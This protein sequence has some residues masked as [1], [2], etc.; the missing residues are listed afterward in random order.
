LQQ[1]GS[2]LGVPYSAAALSEVSKGAVKTPNLAGI[3]NRKP[4]GKF[5]SNFSI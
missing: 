5:S 3:G 4:A 1:N 2:S